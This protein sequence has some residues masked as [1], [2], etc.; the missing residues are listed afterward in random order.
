[1]GVSGDKNELK[2]ELSAESNLQGAGGDEIP[3]EADHMHVRHELEGDWH[4]HEAHGPRS[5]T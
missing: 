2:A 1:M 3:A 5:P 4:G